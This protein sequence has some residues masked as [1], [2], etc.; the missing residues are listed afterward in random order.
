MKLLTKSLLTSF[1]KLGSQELD[2]NPIIIAEFFNP[3]S[4]ETWYATEFN[5]TFNTT[6]NCFYGYVTGLSFDEWGCFSLLEMKSVKL[7]YG[8]GIERDIHF[9]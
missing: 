7:P 1:E 5:T 8:L 6:D 4:S 9:Q 2:K 3:C